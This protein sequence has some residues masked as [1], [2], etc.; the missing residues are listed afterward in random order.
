M[1][2]DLWNTP[3]NKDN[4]VAMNIFIVLLKNNRYVFSVLGNKENIL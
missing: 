1:I 3:L 2:A 4:S